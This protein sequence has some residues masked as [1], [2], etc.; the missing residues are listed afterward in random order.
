L[1]LNSLEKIFNIVSSL[2]ILIALAS[3]F[4]KIKNDKLWATIE[5]ITFFREKI[6]I[7]SSELQKYIIN[8]KPDFIF[9][10]INLNNPTIEYIRKEYSKNFQRQ[11]KLFCDTSTKYPDVILDTDILDK[12]LSL[13]N[14]LEEFS[15][16]VIH[17]G[18]KE[19]PALESIYNAFVEIIE[20]NA[21][22]LLFTRI[23]VEN[24]TYSTILKLY[25]IWEKKT[26]KNSFII[27]V[28]AKHEIISKKQKEEFYEMRKKKQGY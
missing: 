9:S 19:H 17:S 3:Y 18:T 22:A 15:L 11:L 1:G 28:L 23:K 14:I 20:N 2:S 16:K 25:K 4:Y 8:K 27:T 26:S 12:Q 10:R 24:N 21:V 5:Q 7:G 13:L 6:I